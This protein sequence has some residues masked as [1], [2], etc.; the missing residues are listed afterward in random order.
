MPSH[1][2][3]WRQLSARRSPTPTSVLVLPDTV[4]P[5]CASASPMDLIRTW[6][7]PRKSAAAL[8]H[9]VWIYTTPA[10]ASEFL[11]T[12]SSGNLDMCG[13]LCHVLPE[14]ICSTSMFATLSMGGLET[15][16]NSGACWVRLVPGPKG[17]CACDLMAFTVSSQPRV[18]NHSIQQTNPGSFAELTPRRVFLDAKWVCAK[19]GDRGVCNRRHGPSSRLTITYWLRCES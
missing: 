16:R 18:T 11:G 15:R 5:R 17:S 4:A 13:S 7:V 2:L 6:Q 19:A 12:W 14:R 1:I 9:G 8:S 10:Q 3:F